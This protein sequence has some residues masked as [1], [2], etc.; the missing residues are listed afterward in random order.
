MS[1][2]RAIIVDDEG[3]AR[4]TLSLLLEQHSDIEVVASCNNGKAAVDAISNQK[5][6]LVFLDVQMPEMNG[7]EVIEAI[8]SEQMPVV[9]FVTAYDQYALRAFE[10]QALDYLLKPF[11]DERFDQAIERARTLVQQKKVGLLGAQLAELV[12]GGQSSVDLPPVDQPPVDLQV[13]EQREGFL[14]RIMIKGRHSMY[15]LKVE[16][17]DY[18]EAAGDYVSIHINGQSHLL[19]ETMSGLMQK[20]D[21]ARFVRVHRSSIVRVE[22][23]KELKPYFHGDYIIVLN[24]DKEL[25]LSRRYWEQVE[26]VLRS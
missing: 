8:G 14:Q 1:S 20:L 5:P 12:A 25:K 11:D 13:E 24:N 3:L 15:F 16:E 21:P 4:D 26:K 7:F 19:R 6:D 18:I 17:I 10:A 23:I 22:S 2:I 9:I